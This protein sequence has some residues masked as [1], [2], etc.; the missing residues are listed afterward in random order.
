MANNP[1][2]DTRGIRAVTAEEFSALDAM[3]G[4]RGLIESV[5]PGLFFIV[6]FLVT[7]DLMWALVISGAIALLT[8]ALR[9]IQRTKVSQ[10]F[11]GILGIAIGV[12]WAWRTGEATDFFAFGLWQNAIYLAVVLVLQLI[13]WPAVGV[14]IELL[15]FSLNADK[16]S[17]APVGPVE[18]DGFTGDD[19]VVLAA[20]V[21]TMLTPGSGMAETDPESVST[22]DSVLTDSAELKQEGSGNPFAGFSKWRQDRQLLRRYLIASW[23]WVALFGLRLLVQVPLFLGGSVGWL[24]TARLVMG[25][26]LWAAV[27]YATWVVVHGAHRKPRQV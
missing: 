15:R 7:S 3:G 8:V 26:P 17:D 27:L 18:P 5:L 6:I 9:L 1:T 13:S 14:V 16:T 23:F 24:G 22:V 19:G 11:G 21:D 10:A 4:V 20:D 25:V 2:G 12:F